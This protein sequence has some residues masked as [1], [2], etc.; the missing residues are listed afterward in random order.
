MDGALHITLE[1][2][3]LAEMMMSN[4]PLIMHINS[5][6]PSVLPDI[7]IERRF[8]RNR[9]GMHLAPSIDDVAQV[10][11]DMDNMA[12]LPQVTPVGLKLGRANSVFSGTSAR[13]VHLSTSRSNRSTSSSLISPSALIASTTDSLCDAIWGPSFVRSASSTMAVLDMPL[14]DNYSSF[15]LGPRETEAD[16]NLYLNTP[17]TTSD[18][19]L[20]LGTSTA[21]TLSVASSSSDVSDSELQTPEDDATNGVH[22]LEK[23]TEVLLDESVKQGHRLR[24]MGRIDFSTLEK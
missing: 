4:I 1:S 18:S 2:P 3:H 17:A 13:A 23:L 10:P 7:E 12:E 5:S 6:P 16:S 24:R 11:N 22:V 15:Y 20:C 21:R 8:R 14:E 9:L 19:M